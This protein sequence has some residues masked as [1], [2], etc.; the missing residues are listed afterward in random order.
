MPSTDSSRY[1]LYYW[2]VTGRG[3]VIRLLLQYGKVNWS[4]RHPVNWPEDKPNTPFG[5]LPVLIESREDG[6]KFE[7]AES[8]AIERY[9]ARKFGL[10]GADER[11]AALIDSFAEGWGTLIDAMIQIRYGSTDEAKEAGKASFKSSSAEIIQYHEK[12]LKKNGNG[13]YVGSKLSLVD[14]VAYNL[15]HSLKG[16][17][18]K[19]FDDIT[20]FNKLIETVESDSV[21]GSYARERVSAYQLD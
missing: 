9:L 1:E 19:V 15:L 6:T 17:G 21:V 8:H 3:E 10:V 14:L 11:E 20:G 4:E 16:V 7:L 18:N 2:P 12:Q 13:Y 5:C